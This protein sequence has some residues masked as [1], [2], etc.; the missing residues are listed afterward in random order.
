MFLLTTFVQNI[1]A[2]LGAVVPRTFRMY[3]Y[4]PT[5]WIGDWTLF[6]WGWWIAWSPF[7][8]MFI[9]RISRGRS[10]REFVL[11]VLLVPVL[12]T[13]MWM[14]VFG[15]TALWQEL[16]GIAPIAQIVSDDLPVALF[17]MFAGLPLSA[18]ISGVATL[19]VITFFV[20]SADSGALVI[21]MITSGGV[22]GSPAW[23]RGLWAL[24]AGLVAAVLLL[25]GGLQALQ[26]A[27][28][29][30]ALPFVIVMIFICYGLLRA[31]QIES[32][33]GGSG[34]ATSAA[35]SAAHMTWEQRLDTVLR[36]HGRDEL[37][38]VLRHV[39]RPALEEIAE[40]LRTEGLDA[41]TSAAADRIDLVVG[42]GAKD[43]FRYCVRL[44]GYKTPSFA[45]PEQP[46]D[47][48]S[49]HF[50]LIVQSSNS[51]QQHDVTGSTREQLLEDFVARYG[52]FRQSRHGT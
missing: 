49:Q 9:A 30:S 20:T 2:Y 3:A 47:K 52:S 22:T 10:I 43:Q 41:D 33:R 42:H 38:G 26:T 50:R 21:D 37:T 6:Y 16:N 36:S 7:V 48:D 14:T 34:L 18:L 19:L 17:A 12:F 5:A 51:D 46:S 11:G 31:L 27:A 39:A 24:M 40:R 25:A 29:A 15:N 28:I 44:R 23:Q 4:E 32:V 8:G 13:F 45:F 1:G 35:D